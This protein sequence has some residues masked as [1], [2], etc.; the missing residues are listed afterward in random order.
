MQDE[1]EVIHLPQRRRNELPRWTVHISG[2]EIGQI[3]TV[4]IGGS[5]TTFYQALGVLPGWKELVDLELHPDR[6]RQVRRLVEFHDNPESFE[7][8]MDFATRK[9][10][11][12]SA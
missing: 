10:F 9:F 2:V 12:G 7:R 4:H 3:E 1:P 6:E 8:H 11:F 5:R